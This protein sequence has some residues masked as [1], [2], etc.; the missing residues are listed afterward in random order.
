MTQKRS[1]QE[2]HN[3]ELGDDLSLQGTNPG[4]SNGHQI[5]DPYENLN[6]L[7]RSSSPSPPSPNQETISNRSDNSFQTASSD[8]EL[9]VLPAKVTDCYSILATKLGKLP[10][11]EKNGAV[12]NKKLF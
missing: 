1:L 11:T 3:S 5:Q 10:H 4:H 2:N 7:S 9:N 6:S 12:V 8:P